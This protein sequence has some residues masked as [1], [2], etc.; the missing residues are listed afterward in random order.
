MK[1]DQAIERL[2]L[3]DSPVESASVYAVLYCRYNRSGNGL[4]YTVVDHNKLFNE[5]E[6]TLGGDQSR[7]ECRP[8]YHL[9]YLEAT[10]RNS[11]KWRIMTLLELAAFSNRYQTAKALRE[12]W[13]D[14]AKCD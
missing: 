3:L 4:V 14:A 10:Q 9:S 11:H 2:K 7:C 6:R 12:A 13:N 8:Y 1:L 5:L